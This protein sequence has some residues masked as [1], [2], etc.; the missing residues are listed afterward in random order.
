MISEP[1]QVIGVSGRRVSRACRFIL[2]IGLSSKNLAGF[3]SSYCMVVDT[4]LWPP[5]FL[6]F[7]WK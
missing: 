1:S 4:C 7:H 3:Y 5:V 6:H 2:S